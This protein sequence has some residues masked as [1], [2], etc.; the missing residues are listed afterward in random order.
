MRV[1]SYLAE[2][3]MG[4][5]MWPGSWCLKKPVELSTYLVMDSTE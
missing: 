4:D 1:L 3:A 5:Y 2:E